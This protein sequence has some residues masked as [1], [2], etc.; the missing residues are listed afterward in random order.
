MPMNAD[1]I[2][3]ARSNHESLR[4]IASTIPKPSGSSWTAGQPGPASASTSTS[5]SSSFSGPDLPDYLSG[6]GSSL[7]EHSRLGT[8]VAAGSMASYPSTLP[9]ILASSSTG[10]NSRNKTGGEG[11][12][13]SYGAM[14]SAQPQRTDSPGVY[15]L[16][17]PNLQN[18]FPAPDQA[19]TYGTS[20]SASKHEQQV[21]LK[22]KKKSKSSHMASASIADLEGSMR[23][24]PNAD[25]DDA[26]SGRDDR[27]R[28]KTARAC[29]GCR[30]RKIRFARN[31][32]ETSIQV[33]EMG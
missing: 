22:Q 27:K 12:S 33:N 29:D 31:L 3:K 5:T 15:Q 32:I 6:K 11:M 30:S 17:P 20:T 2:A 24:S 21:Q 9:A 8:R 23:E 13:G 28:I 16:P 10:V 1:V 4:A 26:G 18:H 19:S 25:P 7:S 14:Y